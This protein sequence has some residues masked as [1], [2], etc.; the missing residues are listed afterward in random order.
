MSTLAKRLEDLERSSAADL[1]FR[2]IPRFR[3]TQAH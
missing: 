1:G 3:F 2:M